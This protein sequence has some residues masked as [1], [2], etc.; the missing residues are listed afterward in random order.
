MNFIILYEKRQFIKGYI[1]IGGMLYPEIGWY[2]AP[3]GVPDHWTFNQFNSVPCDYQI[4]QPISL[5]K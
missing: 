2:D 4:H 1:Q 5:I 3:V